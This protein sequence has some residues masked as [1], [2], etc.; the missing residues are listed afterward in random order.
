LNKEKASLES[1]G[2]GRIP[3]EEAMR[4]ALANKQKYFPARPES[5]PGESSGGAAP[6]GGPR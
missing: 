6:R 5:R 3:V 1:G 4:I 2:A